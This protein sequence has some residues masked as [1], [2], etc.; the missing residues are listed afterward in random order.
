MRESQRVNNKISVIVPVYNTEVYLPRC[1]DSIVNQ[2]Y[3]DLEIIL[4]DDG[5]TDHSGK[6]CDG[7]ALKDS[8]VKVI[9]KQNGGLVSARQTGINAATGEYIGFVD[10][11][12]WIEKDM[13]R[14]LF[15]I[16]VLENADIVLEG[17]LDDFDGLCTASYNQLPAGKYA[18]LEKRKDLYGKM[19]CCE[20]FFCL[21]I[22]PYLWNKLFRRELVLRHMNI[23]PQ[24]ICV[25]EDAAAVYPM[26]AMA[27]SIVVTDNVHYH[28]CHRAGSMML[29]RKNAGQ[30]Y[31]NALFLHFFLKETF[32]RL[33]M[34]N[35]TEQQLNRYTINNLMARAYDKVAGIDTGSI[36]F[37]FSGICE[38]DSVIIYGAGALGRAVYQYAV[39]CG[40]LTVK[41][42]V[43]RNA[44]NYKR[45][46][47]D[48]CILEETEIEH[49]DKVLVAIFS[50]TA[51]QT[52]YK[53]LVCK[54]VKTGQIRWIDSQADRLV[55][56]MI[57][58]K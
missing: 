18:T 20:E 35:L 14:T 53:K 5:S 29:N 51:F 7:Y 21:G 39:S 49:S 36:L 52:V 17:E 9:H 33:C 56:N 26:L 32:I 8:R 2:T 12:D 3:L 19:L 48:V 4:V 30:E 50:S 44:E 42:L 28:Y 38:G 6:I 46:G 1:I 43:D 58:N 11:D 25:G 45:I 24:S 16:A 57:C 23:I 40:K 55:E 22:Q 13:Y 34:Y 37:P 10:S 47:L 31:N 41:A 15:D 54:G 27:D